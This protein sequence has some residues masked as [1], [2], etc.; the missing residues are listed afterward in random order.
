MIISLKL[1]FCYDCPSHD[2]ATG[3]SG[4]QTYF[5]GRNAHCL[6]V[7]SVYPKNLPLA[8]FPISHT[9]QCENSLLS[10]PYDALN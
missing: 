3:Q 9:L 2:G 6:W 4:G 1:V 8:T 7:Q 10:S 5:R